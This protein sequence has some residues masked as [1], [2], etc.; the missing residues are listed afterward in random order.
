MELSAADL[1]QAGVTARAT[2]KK[3]KKTEPKPP[4]ASSRAQW[5]EEFSLIVV[6]KITSPDVWPNFKLNQALIFDEL[7]GK[8]AAKRFHVTREQIRNHWNSL[9]SKYK[10]ARRVSN[11][12]G[13]AGDVEARD[14]DADTDNETDSDGD[15]NKK[16]KK[17]KRKA[18][19]DGDDDDED[20][21]PMAREKA[22][23]FANGT[24]YKKIDA[25]A[26]DDPDVVRGK[27]FSSGEPIKERS[28]SHKRARTS[29]G[30][31][32]S[33]KR[34][35]RTSSSSSDSDTSSSASSDSDDDDVGRG[36]LKMIKERSKR[37]A[38]ID[39][40]NL[41][42]TEERN[43]HDA[44]RLRIER[45]KHE[46]EQWADYERCK[47]SPDPVLQRRAELLAKKLLGDA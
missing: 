38:R 8:L 1:A 44:E 45:E 39:K 27:V 47:A 14:P 7:V 3:K 6:D 22:L 18:K 5:S 35:S 34:K 20:R 46:R 9:W 13:G 23:E 33:K 26:H 16:D 19:E 30:K 37:Q 40:E 4:A 15:S 2:T 43:K 41:A 17:R 42:L 29:K 12:T 28:K 24:I 36:I 10:Q 25:V 11:V 32:K 31:K 21:K